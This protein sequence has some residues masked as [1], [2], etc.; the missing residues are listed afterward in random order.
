VGEIQLR[1]LRYFVAVAEELHF[2]RAARRLDMAQPPL[3]QQI[4][5][6]EAE[7]GIELFRRYPRRI[8]LTRGGKLLLSHAE[9]LLAQAAR[10]EDVMRCAAEATAGP[11]TIGFARS[12]G[13]TLLPTVLRRFHERYPKVQL[14]LQEQTTP[15][16]NALLLCG[17]I[18]VGIVR[19]HL[20]DPD[21]TL[22]PLAKERMIAAL[23]E[24]HPLS[25]APRLTMA[26][27]AME[28]FVFLSRAVSPVHYDLLLTACRAAGFNPHIT[29][30][31]PDPASLISLISAGLFVALVPQ[32]TAAAPRPHVVYREVEDL[33]T[34]VDFLLAYRTER[35]DP[36]VKRFCEIAQSTMARCALLEPFHDELERELVTTSV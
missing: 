4:Q 23:P 7:L 2:G 5:R 26:D 24:A 34:T 9:A 17:R 29:Q 14:A 16:Q 15:R 21:I 30:E 3:S 11:L 12:A 1:R 33:S 25:L 36:I 22:D 19:Q 32:S 18:D 6:L 28:R 35:R 13:Y 10:L 31:A 8:E 27:L 20:P